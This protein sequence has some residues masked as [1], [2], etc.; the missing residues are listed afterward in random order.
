M[1]NNNRGL[2]IRS[3][4]VV[5][6]VLAMP[7]EVMQQVKYLVAKHPKECQWF[8]TV[9]RVEGNNGHVFY[10]L[11]GLYIPDQI[12]SGAEVESDGI[13]IMNLY[14]A[15]KQEMNFDFATATQEEIDAYNDVVTRMNVWCHSHVNMATNPSS[16]DEATFA[17]YVKLAIEGGVSEPQIMLIF[18]KKNEYCSRVFDPKYDLYFENVPITIDYPEVDYSSVDRA[19]ASKIKIRKPVATVTNRTYMTSSASQKKTTPTSHGIAWGGDR[20]Y[21]DLDDWLSYYEEIYGEEVFSDF[22]P[23]SNVNSLQSFSKVIDYNTESIIKL[24]EEINNK[25]NNIRAVELLLEEIEFIAGDENYGALNA[26]LFG[27]EQDMKK[28]YEYIGLQNTNCFQEKITFRQN[29]LE[30]M[31]LP[32]SLMTEA[33]DIINEIEYADDDGQAYLALDRFINANS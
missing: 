8:H 20:D 10:E 33:L 12:T 18:N 3:R 5:N 11:D 22:G 21:K 13:E 19:L 15:V 27:D 24:V 31:I 26:L 4:V 17:K 32:P 7:F 23:D 29:L 28:I 25:N 16:T 6:P 30:G 9:R 1:F 14:E 2:S